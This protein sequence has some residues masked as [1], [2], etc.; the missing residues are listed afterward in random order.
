MPSTILLGLLRRSEGKIYKTSYLQLRLKPL[1]EG[2]IFQNKNS[3]FSLIS[4]IWLLLSTDSHVKSFCVVGLLQKM[5]APINVAS[6]KRISP[7]CAGCCF[8]TSFFATFV[9]LIFHIIN[10][11]WTIC[12]YQK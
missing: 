2:L 5:I 10:I 9:N 11:L 8:R 4:K 1:V 3:G 12:I 7:H 6:S